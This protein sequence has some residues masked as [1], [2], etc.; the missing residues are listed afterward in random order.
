MPRA[1]KG[2]RLELKHY[3]DRSPRWVIRDGQQT[4]GTGC[5]ECDRR[6]AERKLAQYIFAKHDPAKGLDKNNP[7]QAKIADILSLEMQRLAKADMPDWRKRELITVCQNMGNWFGDRVVGDLNGNLQERY[8]TERTRYVFAKVHGDRV[9][10]KTD[11][12]APAAAWRDLKFLAAAVNRYLKTEIGGVESRFSPVL[13]DAPQSRERYLTRD[14]AAK[15]IRTAW[16][17]RK[18]TKLADSQGRHT[19][20]HIARYILVALYTGSRNGDICG[21]AVIPTIGRGY[22]DLDRGIFKRKPD[23][24]KATSKR[25]PTIPLPPRLLAHMRRWQRLGISQR[26]VIEFNGKPI[27]RVRDG[28]ET[29]IQKAGL[30]TDDARQKIVRHTLRHTAITWYLQP[31][32]RTGKGLDIETVSLYCGVSVATIRK[33]YRHVMAG[34]FKP[35]LEAAHGFGR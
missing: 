26:A 12:P 20:R 30:G 6:G 27:T 35:L 5:D 18:A 32:H 3:R 28:W 11:I 21:A 1:S 14:E 31:D 8:A 7:N 25:Q 2:P 29:L 34:T 17:L 4:L 33:T 22:V 23:N 19:S 15:L 10:I 9:S 16:R 24:K 13:P